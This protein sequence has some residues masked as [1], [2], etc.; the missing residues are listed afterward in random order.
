MK[1]IPIMVGDIVLSVGKEIKS[2][3]A[4]SVIS[5]VLPNDEELNKMTDTQVWEWEKQNNKRMLSICKFLN[6]NPGL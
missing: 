3:Y 5:A 2:G 1:Y 4:E 6:E